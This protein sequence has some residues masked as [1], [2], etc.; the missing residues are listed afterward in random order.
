[1]MGREQFSAMREGS[2][3]INTARASLV[4]GEALREALESGHLAGAALDVFPVEP[5]ASDDPVVARPDVIATPHLGGNT[6][7]VA[8][9]QGAIAAEQ[10]RKLLRGERPDYLLNPEVLDLFDWTAPR[11]EP[12]AEELERLSRRPRPSMTS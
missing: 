11:P 7:E 5:P 8:A 10:L 1:M 6:Y 2:Y 4:D 12:P 9:H 3:F